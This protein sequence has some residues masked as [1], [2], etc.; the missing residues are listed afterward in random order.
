MS[1]IS[2]YDTLVFLDVVSTLTQLNSTQ[3]YLSDPVVIY[4]SIVYII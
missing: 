4:K 2:M 1:N 3:N